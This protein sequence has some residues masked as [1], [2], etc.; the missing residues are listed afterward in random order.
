MES[1]KHMDVTESPT[2]SAEPIMTDK[3]I[4]VDKNEPPA[5]DASVEAEPWGAAGVAAALIDDAGAADSAPPAAPADP[6]LVPTP[7]P[8]SAPQPRRITVLAGG[9]S[10]EREVS[11]N[12]GRNSAQALRSAG[13][14]VSELDTADA[15]FLAKLQADRPDVVFLALHGKYGEDGTI[16]GML[17]F[18]GLPY[19][20]SGVLASALAMDKLRS[21]VFYRNAGLET[22]DY[23]VITPNMTGLDTAQRFI[24]RF[25]LP[26]VVKPT[27]DGSSLGISVVRDSDDLPAAL[28]KAFAVSQTIML[29]RFIS[30]TEI[31]VPVIGTNE[32]T[33]LPV[34]E[35][36]PIVSDF[37]DYEAKYA[38]GG[39]DHIIPARLPQ[40]VLSHAQEQAVRAHKA[41]GCAGMSRSDFIV[42]ALGTPWILE[43]NTIPGMTATSLLPDSARHAGI[44]AGELY[45]RIVEWAIALHGQRS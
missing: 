32:V 25:N 41:L 15:D 30:G 14:Q 19:T 8:Y 27:T 26:C 4:P 9:S 45:T 42:D 22:P 37:Y 21:K 23:V 40:G 13:H 29:E 28:D 36:V 24:E 1:N 35:I 31:T 11:L 17:E 2:N 10:G 18:V 20:G 3:E 5:P 38:D 34:I 43:T 6:A 33:A 44:E 16:Q 7:K 39:S 12:S